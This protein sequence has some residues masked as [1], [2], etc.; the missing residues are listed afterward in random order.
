M[1]ATNTAT[2]VAGIK[3]QLSRD[4]G[5]EVLAKRAYGWLEIWLDAKARTGKH[6]HRVEITIGKTKDGHV[7]NILKLTNQKPG[8]PPQKLRVDYDS[9]SAAEESL[10]KDIDSFGES[11]AEDQRAWSAIDAKYRKTLAYTEFAPES[12]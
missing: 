9:F 2:R 3:W 5:G 11:V 7:A 12:V 1:N 10:A 8:M 6:V 4:P